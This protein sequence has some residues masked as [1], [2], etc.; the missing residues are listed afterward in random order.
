MLGT[1]PAPH[2]RRRELRRIGRAN[3]VC[4]GQILGERPD[5]LGWQYLIPSDA[6]LREQPHCRGPFVPHHTTM[7]FSSRRSR[8]PCAVAGCE[9]QRATMALASQNATLSPHRDRRVT[10]RRVE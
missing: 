6:K 5:L 3:A 7:R 10:H 2:E 8:R 1:F 9:Q 4:I